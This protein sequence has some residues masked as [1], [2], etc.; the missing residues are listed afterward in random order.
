MKSLLTP[1]TMA[2]SDNGS[3]LHIASQLFASML[4]ITDHACA[5]S[6]KRS[7]HQRSFLS[8]VQALFDSKASLSYFKALGVTTVQKS[9]QAPDLTP[10]VLTKAPTITTSLDYLTR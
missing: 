6:G 3:S 8:E 5:L 4:G 10:I 2:F 7:G 9:S 1:L